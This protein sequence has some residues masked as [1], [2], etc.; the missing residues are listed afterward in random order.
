MKQGKLTNEQL[1]ASVLSYIGQKRGETAV[2]PAVG[3]DCAVV[4]WNDD[5]IVMTTDPITA[6]GNGIGSLA[7][8]VCCNDLASAGAEPVALL[9]T[10][11]AP[12]QADI[13][14]IEAVMRDAQAA[15]EDVQ[16]DIVGGHTEVTDAVTRIVV[17][18]TAIGRAAKAPVST[19][20][21]HSGDAIVMT[22]WAGLEGTL[23]LAR[24]YHDKLET[25]VPASILDEG[26]RLAG[27]LSVLPESRVAVRHG[28]TA[29]HDITE[30][31]VFGA[32]WEMAHASGCGAHIVLSA[33]PM[34]ESTRLLCR[35]IDANPYRMIS[36]GCLLIACR[37][38]EKLCRALEAQNIPCA[39]IGT[40]T[41]GKAVVLETPDGIEPIDPPGPDEIYRI[42]L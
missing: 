26:L 21:M 11:L 30:G 37:D 25:M 28:A 8:E 40:A 36:S 24:D 3:E 20:G 14:D 33:I 19:S 12:P 6:A 16:A 42:N 7:V 35:K 31:G 22:K 29:M 9:L 41:D 34:L 27:C 23:I 15:A 1:R 13:A 5:F 17:S 38:G 10:L 18:A 2:G 32:V 4:R 39:V